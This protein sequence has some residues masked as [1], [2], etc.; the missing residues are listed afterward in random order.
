MK[1]ASDII[2][3]RQVLAERFPNV[4]PW[5]EESA[6]RARPCWP[7]GLPFLDALL[8]GGLPKGAVTEI[9]SSK[10]SAG[11]A[12]FLRHLLHQAR[13]SRQ[14]IALV[15]GANTFDPAELPS[16]VLSRLLWVRC[17]MAEEA[18]KAADIVLRDRNLPLVA[19]DFKLNPAAQLRKISATA[20]YRLQ[21]LAQGGGGVLLVLSP[22]PVAACADVRLT[23]ESRWSLEDLDREESPAA[24]KFDL[25]RW[26]LGAHPALPAAEAG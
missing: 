12:T 5:T 18:M 7:T 15:D 25:T 11:S 16:A 20:W 19:L 13:R 10:C 2:Q 8:L 14:P 17:R 23:L 24:L 6:A 4:R 9:V 26:A 1:A 22:L 3:L 21:R